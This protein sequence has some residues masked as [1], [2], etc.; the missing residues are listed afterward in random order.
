MS[1][2][3][4]RK[5]VTKSYQV[6]HRNVKLV[7]SQQRSCGSA[8]SRCCH[9]HHP[10][11]SGVPRRVPDRIRVAALIFMARTSMEKLAPVLETWSSTAQT[12]L[13]QLC[14]P[15]AGRSP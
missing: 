1:G 6:P 13:R 7:A 15:G 11:P 5:L 14:S 4:H 8:S 3:A 9:R 2:G 12:G 10:G